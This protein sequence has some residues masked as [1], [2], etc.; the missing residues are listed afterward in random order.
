MKRSNEKMPT[1]ALLVMALVTLT[2]GGLMAQA[3]PKK[4]WYDETLKN[5]RVTCKFSGA[6]FKGAHPFVQRTS[7]LM[8]DGLENYPLKEA[9]GIYVTFK[10]KEKDLSSALNRRILVEQTL[11]DGDSTISRTRKMLPETPYAVLN[12]PLITEQHFVK[13]TC[14]TSK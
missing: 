11:S 12:L 6:L 10:A 13:M 9:A 2:C 7:F 8:K 14:K 1:F 4:S 5:K 3:L